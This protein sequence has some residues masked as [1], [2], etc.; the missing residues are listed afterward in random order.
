[1]SCQLVV[2]NNR[3]VLSLEVVTK[4]RP[5]GDIL[6]CNKYAPKECARNFALGRMASP[7]FSVLLA[8]FGFHTN[9]SA[10]LFA[11]INV[12]FDTSTDW[13]ATLPC[14]DVDDECDSGIKSLMHLEDPRSHSLTD[15]F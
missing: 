15:P 7:P 4:L 11:A 2:S 6:A 8:S 10:W 3:A 14:E 12:S 9:T 5:S 13:I 1:M